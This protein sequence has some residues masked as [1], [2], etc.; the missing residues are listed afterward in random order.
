MSD[1]ELNTPAEYVAICPLFDKVQ[2]A[3]V[4]FTC[5]LYACHTSRT[6]CFM[7]SCMLMPI[8]WV[9]WYSS[10]L[11]LKISR[12]AAFDEATYPVDEHLAWSAAEHLYIVRSERP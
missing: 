2:R 11:L 3:S 10:K 12:V 6:Q 5:I 9:C 8:K 1:L 4:Y 7:Y